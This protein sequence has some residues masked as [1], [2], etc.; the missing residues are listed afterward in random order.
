MSPFLAIPLKL[1]GLPFFWVLLFRDHQRR[2]HWRH[3][4]QPRL[5]KRSL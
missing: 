5:G 1:L 4:H 2:K 3:T